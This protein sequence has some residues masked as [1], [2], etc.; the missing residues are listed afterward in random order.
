MPV[1]DRREFGGRFTVK[2]NSQRLA[3]YRYLE[4]QLM[5]MMGGWSHTTPQLAYKA[6][7]GYHVYDHAQAAD[8]LGERLE[9]LRS[10]RDREEPATDAFAQLC[11][12]I[13]NLPSVL[14]RLVAVYRVLEPHLVS[15]YVYHADATDPLTD[16]PTVRLLRQLAAMG[17]SH[18][19]WG[20]AVLDGLARSPEDR[21][22][23]LEVQADIE[24]RLVECGGVTGQGIESHWLAFHS[25]RDEKA[26]ARIKRGKSGYRYQKKCTPLSHPVAEAPFWFSD[27]P[28]DF[29]RCYNAQDEWSIEGFRDKFHQL[30]YGEVETTDRMGKMLAEFPELPWEMRMELAH[31]MWDEARHIEI[32]AKAIEE[33]LGG[34]L[35]YGPW[36]L[37]WWWM[38]NDPDPLKR[39]TVTNA[40]AERNL[41]QTL[42]IWRTEA[43]KR[44]YTRIAELSDYLQADEL[45]HVKLATHWLRH[46]TEENPEKRDELVRWG[47]KAVA[48][49]QGF[50][51][52]DGKVE[53]TEPEVHFSF[54]RAGNEEPVGAMSNVIG[55]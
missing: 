16:T 48:H 43:E 18:V 49:I 31:Q 17:Q 46:F 12:H 27:D 42:R 26:P 40:W 53:G 22:R 51:A 20:Q 24:A 54:L 30:L 8:L 2:E 3:N 28:Q 15:T 4:V 11:E 23:A 52:K 33:E 41:M 38:Q 50:H 9:Q 1:V 39:I 6:T 37:V 25:V 45:T 32:V 19:A 5:E 47:T 29:K 7:F 35:G 36:S 10:G 44:G 21:R 13:W 14:E 55:E 34:E